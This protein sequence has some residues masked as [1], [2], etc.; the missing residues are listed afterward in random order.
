[1]QQ[2]EELL[3]QKNQFITRYQSLAHAWNNFWSTR[4][5]GNFLLECEDATESNLCYNVKNGRNLILV[6]SRGG[7]ENAFDCFTWGS[8]TGLDFYGVMWAGNAQKV[9]NS[10]GVDVSSNI[11]YSCNLVSCLFCLACNGL[12]NSQ[13]CILN[14]EYPKEERFVLAD[15]IFAQMEKEGVLGKFFPW[16][17]N[18]MY[19]NDTMAS[20]IEDFSKEEIVWEGFLWRDEK[21]KIDIPESV[22]VISTSALQ[23]FQFFD[24]EGKRVINSQVLNK[25]IKDTQWD[26]YKIIPLELSFLQK[27]WLPLPELH[28][29]E[30]IKLGFKFK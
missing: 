11:Y 26:Y 7:T 3:R 1:M 12:S 6:G 14:K 19:F 8:P 23:N 29:L 4:V 21:I 24:A 16:S 20:L 27:Y 25:V 13:F 10:T 5:E 22:D 17:L 18:P 30:R 9:F 15:K 28:R 2:K